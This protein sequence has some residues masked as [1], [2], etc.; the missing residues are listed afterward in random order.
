ASAGGSEPG[1]QAESTTARNTTLWLDLVILVF[2][3]SRP[4][5]A[6]P[7]YRRVRRIPR[8]RLTWGPRIGPVCVMLR[9]GQICRRRSAACPRC[10]IAHTTCSFQENQVTGDVKE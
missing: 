3:L 8:S 2:L 6:A 1:L 4:V 5:R 7:L 9:A 10:A